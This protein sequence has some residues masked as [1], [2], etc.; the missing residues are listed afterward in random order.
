MI[1]GKITGEISGTFTVISIGTKVLFCTGTSES[2]WWR[3]I[4]YSGGTGAAVCH[5]HLVT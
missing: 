1:E 3:H 4:D 2:D 5:S